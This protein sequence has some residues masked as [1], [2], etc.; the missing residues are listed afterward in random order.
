MAYRP[1]K[2]PFF[3]RRR[4]TEDR[5]SIHRRVPFLGAFQPGG[6]SKR[7]RLFVNIIKF[8]GVI[9]LIG[10]IAGAVSLSILF[11][12]V[13]RDL[14][15][16][17]HLLDRQTQATTKIWDRTGTH[18]LYE[19]HGSEK[20]TV[21]QLK[22]VS[23]YAINAAIASE[24]RNFYQHHGVELQSFIRAIFDRVFLGKRLQGTSTITQQVVK[25]V[26]LSSERS[27]T[28]KAK[29]LILSFEIERK[30]S[31]D[32]ILQI[33]FNE[34]PY[35]STAYGV[36]SASQMYYGKSAKDLDPAE[37]ALLAAIVPAPTRLSPYG[38]AKDELVSRWKH[39]L[40]A[41]HDM[42]NLTD[43]EWVAAKN[44][45]VLSHVKPRVENIVAPHFSL[46]VKEL[47]ADQ[48][49]E[50]VVEEGGLNVITTL[51]Y[52][53]QV[54]AEQAIKDG[55]DVVKKNGGSNAALVAEDVKTGQ[56][57]A[58]V[59]S[60]DYFDTAHDGNVNVAIR[61]RQPGSSFKP[62]VYA[63]AFEKGYT[64]NTV[65]FDVNTKFPTDT[66]TPYEPHDYDLGERGPLTLKKAL[67]GSLN[68]P[69][70]KTLYLTG[71]DR[72]LDFAKTLGYTTLDD[73][74][75]FGL[76]LVLGGAEVKLVEHVAAFGAFASEGTYRAPAYILKVEDPSG[77]T[78]QEWKDTPK[79]NVMGVETAR[80][81]ND[82]LSDNDNR[83]YIFGAQNHLTLPD[84]PVAAKTGTTNNF[85]DAW[86]MGY[87]PSLVAG[88]WT[89]NNDNT[90]MKKGADGSKVAAP[91]W[92]A[93]MEAALK[94][95]PPEPFN[96]PQPIVTGKPVLDGQAGEIHV[97]I[98]KFSGKL[99][100]ADTPPTAI[101]DR[102]Y[103][104]AHDIL[105]YV[106]KEDPRGPNPADPSLD[107]Q[108]AAW[109]AGVADWAARNDWVT[110]EAPPTETD[111]VHDGSDAPTVTFLEPAENTA[112]AERTFMAKVTP[113]GPRAVKRVE[114]TI[115]GS[116][117]G[118]A[119]G[120]PWEAQLTLPPTYGRGFYTLRATAYDDIEDSGSQDVTIN[121]TSDGVPFAFNWLR[122]SSD[123]TY[124]QRAF[125]IYIDTV[126]NAHA[127]IGK[128]EIEADPIATDATTDTTP[129]VL[130]SLSQPKTDG[131][132][133]SWDTAPDPGAYRLRADITFANG[134]T[135]DFDG[136]KVVVKQ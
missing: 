90:V 129:I 134:D 96:A 118:T 66:G 58:M 91:I 3:L 40:D 8:I 42:G 25:N 115:D 24:D 99:A 61:P 77:K 98:D 53:K 51:D 56:V 104:Q 43:Q 59:G 107:P 110:T 127:G 108:F 81:I 4:D 28:R 7:W 16:P 2:R 124:R 14:P 18:L 6:S 57:L 41:E 95:T 46:Y 26:I 73:R 37:G 12:W 9:S 54:A 35:G 71:I 30:F 69:A 106:D 82:I 120:Y 62:I 79:E 111:D 22:D 136:P 100:T 39:I 50:R 87:T 78:L 135:K 74:S 72:A 83:A 88:V 97:Q 45:D 27:L 64:P 63:A 48:Y 131:V 5:A 21:V 15:D 75:R 116:L 103:R 65:V 105:E 80:N 119:T 55:M 102:V 19:I 36:E 121:V 125:P 13:S 112:V 67:G 84:R 49:G 85:V 133:V 89:G 113:G 94:D 44:E 128:V 70:V 60:A 114:F 52:D 101:E 1:K 38:S 68:I 132:S 32:Q 17:N 86:T 93:F 33:Y 126:M 10:L 31:K 123:I 29:E 122:P 20:R 23:K 34:T 92:Q 76:S 109:E 11:A 117:I 130:G 47:L